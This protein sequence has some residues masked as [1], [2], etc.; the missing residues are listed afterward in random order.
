VNIDH[1]PGTGIFFAAD[2]WQMSFYDVAVIACASSSGAGIEVD[3]AVTTVNQL[4]WFNLQ[5]ENNGQAR[6]SS[7][8]GI[9][10]NTTAV[11]QW[12]FY[13]GIFQG[14]KGAAEARFVNGANV[15]LFGVYLESGLAASGAGDGLIFGGGVTVALINMNFHADAGH[16]GSAIRC[17]GSSHCSVE[18]LTVHANW[19]VAI[20]TEGEAVV[21]VLSSG[22][23]IPGA[24]V[25]EASTNP[26]VWP[27]TRSR[28]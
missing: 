28:Q 21:Q 6:S 8:G 7:G 12:D 27:N 20:R 15:G 25:S 10:L 16:G 5:L 22:N 24:G 1:F 17:T 14:N 2:E 23:L 9:N 26:I 19:P 18:N 4:N 11:H 3:S 13:G